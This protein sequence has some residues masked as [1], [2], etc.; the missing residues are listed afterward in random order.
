MGKGKAPWS[1]EKK[2]VND[3]LGETQSEAKLGILL[4]K[5]ERQL[6]RIAKKEVGS[7]FFVKTAL[8]RK[9]NC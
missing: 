9:E 1:G 3:L 7:M 6:Y 4:G 2:R 5:S 8:N